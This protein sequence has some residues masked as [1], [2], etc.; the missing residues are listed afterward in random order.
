MNELEKKLEAQKIKKLIAK[1]KKTAD[2]ELLKQLWKRVRL[3]R[4]KK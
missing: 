3:L 4:S 1:V 2:P